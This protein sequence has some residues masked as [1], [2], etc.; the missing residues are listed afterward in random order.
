MDKIMDGVVDGKPAAWQR[1]RINHTTGA[2]FNSRQHASAMTT[3][4]TSLREQGQ[5]P[6][7]PWD[8]PLLVVATFV[9]AVRDK[10]KHGK[11]C[12][13]RPDTDNLCKLVG[14]A[15]NG[16]LWRDDAVLSWRATKVYGAE[17]KTILQ[18]YRNFVLD[19]VL[20]ERY[21]NA[22]G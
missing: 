11:L 15:G 14:D 13:S 17:P 22:S 21:N 1:A 18:V 4:L 6:E 16:V 7:T 2:I 10:K 5:I 12:V 3:F 19:D 20:C 8:E 9:F